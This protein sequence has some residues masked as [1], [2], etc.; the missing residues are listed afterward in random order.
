GFLFDW[1]TRVAYHDLM[2]HIP[3]LYRRFFAYTGSLEPGSLFQKI[4]E[5]CG[6]RRFLRYLRRNHPV[7]LISTFPVPSAVT[8]HLKRKGL[9]SSPLA[10][11]VTDY[12]LHR[13]W[14]QPGTDLYIVADDSVAEAMAKVGVPRSRIKV[15][16]IPIDPRF[17]E[18]RSLGVGA[19]LPGLSPEGEKGSPL[20]LVLNGATGFRGELPSICRLLAEFP[21]PLVAVVLG[22]NHPGVRLALRSSVRNGRNRVLVLGYSRQVPEFMRAATCLISK[23]GGI[24]VSEALAAELPMIIYKPLPCQ[25]EDN[26]D[27]MV[28]RGAALAPAT[29]GELAEAL[30]RLLTEPSLRERMREAASRLKKPD[31]AHRIALLLRPYIIDG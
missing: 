19:L 1:L 30:E 21:L 11:V 3:W 15:T 10:T 16:G 26:R 17:G 31:A 7:L 6:R 4:I 22:V 28:K 8:S 29:I 25:E 12:T 14:V 2:I 18:G 13:Q 24:T 23:G 27:F 5:S 9:L 20:V